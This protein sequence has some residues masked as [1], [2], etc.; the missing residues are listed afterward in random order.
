MGVTLSCAGVAA[1]AQPFLAVLL[2]QL[3]PHRPVVVVTDNLKTQESFQQDLTTWLQVAATSEPVRDVQAATG[4]P[5]FYPAWEVLPHEG[6]LPHADVISDRLQTLVALLPSVERAGQNAGL[7]V[8]SVTALL[9]R[10]FAPDELQR[11]IRPLARGDRAD[12]L[13]LV[14]WLEAQGYEPEAQVTQKGEIA[15]R[16]GI[17]DVFPPTSP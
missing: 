17:V 14:E 1:A 6:R 3:F 4:N 10:T 2:R 11:R 13:D 16:G 5:L 8:T 9:Q 12:P 15:L 7:I